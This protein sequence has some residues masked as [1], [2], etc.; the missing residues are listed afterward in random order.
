MPTRIHPTFDF[1]RDVFDFANDVNLPR[2]QGASLVKSRLHH[3]CEGM[4]R[5]WQQ[6]WN[7]VR[8]EEGARLDPAEE[9]RRVVQI[10]RRPVWKPPLGRNERQVLPGYEGLRAFSRIHVAWL[11]WL[12]DTLL[13][14]HLRLGVQRMVYPFTRQG[15]QRQALLTLQNLT[16][17]EPVVLHCSRFPIISINHFVVCFSASDTG[18]ILELK[19]YD[20]NRPTAPI[21]LTYDKARRQ[22]SYPKTHYFN[23]GP[24]HVNRAYRSR[25]W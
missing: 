24:V 9:Q 5:A 8:F 4:S 7:G 2:Q 16:A 12:F 14:T 6:F 21:M 11:P 19:A 15:Q 20:P 23:G 18:P 17:G 13:R 1:Q 25:L 3:R 10:L 22:F